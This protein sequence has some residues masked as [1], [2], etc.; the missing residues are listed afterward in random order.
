MAT[1]DDFIRTALRVPPDL[2]KAIHEAASAANRTF[3]AEIVARLSQSFESGGLLPD[4]IRRGVENIAAEDG[5]T[6]GEALAKAVIAGLSPDAPAVLYFA[7]GPGMKLT[8]VLQVFDQ[9]KKKLPPDTS[10]YY[11]MTQAPKKSKSKNKI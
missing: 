9:A 6:F 2:H 1:Q 10:I 4:V 11:D 3:N 8:D 7:P 5:V